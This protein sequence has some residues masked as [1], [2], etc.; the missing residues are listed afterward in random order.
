MNKIYLIGNVT[1]EVELSKTPSGVQVCRF[2]LAVSRDYK[3]ENG[4]KVTDFFNCT[5]WRNLAETIGKYIKK[6]NKLAV[7]GSVQMRNYEDNQGIKRTAIDVIVTDCEFLT[8]KSEETPAPKAKPT[9][10]ECDEQMDI[11]F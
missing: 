2:T 9:L 6:G 7:V 10:T 3:N 11:P 1:K 4:E 5:A 8:P